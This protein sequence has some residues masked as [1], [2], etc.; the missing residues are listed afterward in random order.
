MEERI[1]VLS[2]SVW[3]DLMLSMPPETRAL[4]Y[5]WPEGSTQDKDHA[6]LVLLSPFGYR[7]LFVKEEKQ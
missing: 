1:C 3:V 4:N 7:L 5:R 2:K 6:A